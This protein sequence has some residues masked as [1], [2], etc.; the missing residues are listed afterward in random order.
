MSL[1]SFTTRMRAVRHTSSRKAAVIHTATRYMKMRP[2]VSL[3]L[4]LVRLGGGAGCK[5]FDDTVFA[6]RSF[7]SARRAAFGK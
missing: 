4:D 5:S 6:S 2:A 7:S 1:D 3:R